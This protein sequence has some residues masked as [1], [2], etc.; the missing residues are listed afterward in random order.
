MNAANTTEQ[1]I[2]FSLLELLKEHSVVCHEEDMGE[3]QK[4]IFASF[5]MGTKDPIEFDYIFNLVKSASKF[6]MAHYNYQSYVELSG[7]V[8]KDNEKDL[9][10]MISKINPFL[11]LGSFGIFDRLGSLYWKQNTLLDKKLSSE[12][13]SSTIIA[14]AVFS[15]SVI[16]DFR[17]TLLNFLLNRKSAEDCLRE[18]K[19]S[20]LMFP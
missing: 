4:A 16:M 7:L 6:E 20:K 10:W 5:T 14:E 2:R 15:Q 9:A 12:Q 3:G 19:W 13:L 8:N 11:P 1:E 17:D 18:N